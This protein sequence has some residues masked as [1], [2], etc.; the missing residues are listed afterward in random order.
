MYY[1]LVV[2]LTLPHIILHT[3]DMFDQLF[4]LLM[5]GLGLATPVPSPTVKGESTASAVSLGSELSA[6]EDATI[7]SSIVA[8]TS[9]EKQKENIIKREKELKNIFAERKARLAQELKKKREEAVETYKEA[10][11]T[12]KENVTKIRDT[13]KQAIITNI[14][15]KITEINKKRTDEMTDRLSK[16]S[17]ILDKVGVRSSEAK[18]AGKDI[19]KVEALVSAA[20]LALTTAQSTVSTQAGKTYVADISS[21]ETVGQAMSTTLAAVKT[22]VTAVYEVVKS[23]HLSVQAAVKELGTLL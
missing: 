8:Y 22:D 15:T 4:G 12:F 10:R 19:T 14:D 16:M 21:V 18:I 17:E 6:S 5:F 2:S 9:R 1:N 11:E 7:E 20:R 23:A 13:K 3:L